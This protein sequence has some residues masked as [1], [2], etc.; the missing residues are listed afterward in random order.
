MGAGPLAGNSG[1]VGRSEADHGRGQ[2][3]TAA[4]C[5]AD[6][7]PAV[8]RPTHAREEQVNALVHVA[9]EFE[10]AWFCALRLATERDTLSRFE[11]NAY[12]ESCLI[13]VRS[14]YDFLCRNSTNADDI[15]RTDF[16]P[17]WAP[18][19]EAAE[20][21]QRL[22]AEA[23][24]INKYLAHL[25]WTRLNTSDQAPDASRLWQPIDLF[26]DVA[27]LLRAWADHLAAEGPQDLLPCALSLRDAATR[28]LS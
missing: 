19:G 23:P 1:E 8:V 16:A 6:Y 26:L 28:A 27:R 24:A 10:M 13:H 20:A 3:G 4:T 5:P 12:L 21:T 2:A 15:V 17:P 14:L 22:E 9:Y 7:A 25:S 11:S 18:T